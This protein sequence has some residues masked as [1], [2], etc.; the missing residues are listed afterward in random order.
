MHMQK[1]QVLL[2]L[3]LLGMCLFATI[4]NVG[5]IGLYSYVCDQ[6]GLGVIQ[7]SSGGMFLLV[8]SLFP[9][10]MVELL[11]GISIYRHYTD[12]SVYYFIRQKNFRVWFHKEAIRLFVVIF[13]TFFVYMLGG[14]AIGCILLG[15]KPN[16]SVVFVILCQCAMFTL[17]AY[18]FSLLI[19]CVSII[20]GSDIAY[21]IGIGVQ[22][23]FVMLL[24]IFEKKEITMQNE[25]LLRWNP[26]SCISIMWHYIPYENNSRINMLGVGFDVLVSCIYLALICM[27]IYFA[28]KVALANRDIAME[29][30]EEQG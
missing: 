11:E 14:L 28:T 23:I 29:N 13:E 12:G 9:I 3:L 5:K 26:I 17:Y 1:K 20:N 30:K 25:W 19:N 15:E 7:I 18:A 8:S 24:M 21:V 6:L 2:L 22:L 27:V 4:P 16:M 10:I